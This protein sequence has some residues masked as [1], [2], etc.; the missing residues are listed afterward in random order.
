[1]TRGLESFLVIVHGLAVEID[2]RGAQ[3]GG[4]ADYPRSLYDF[5]WDAMHPSSP[6]A[7]IQANTMLAFR[8][9]QPQGAPVP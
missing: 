4:F 6:Y 3:A 5:D 9:E 7:R 2:P 1:M 8:R